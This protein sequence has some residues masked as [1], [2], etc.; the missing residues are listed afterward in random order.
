MLNSTL[1]S[2]MLPDLIV[3]RERCCSS[4]LIHLGAACDRLVDLY[5][6]MNSLN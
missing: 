3:L 5:I 4:L 6:M 1:L 2:F